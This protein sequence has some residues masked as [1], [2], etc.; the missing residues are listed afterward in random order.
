MWAVTSRNT[1][2]GL[3]V[4]SMDLP[5][6]FPSP[7]VKPYGPDCWPAFEV[8]SRAM[9]H[10]EMIKRELYDRAF[11]E[12]IKVLARRHGELGPD[13]TRQIM[14]YVYDHCQF[15]NLPRFEWYAKYDRASER[16]G[17]RPLGEYEWRTSVK[18]PKHMSESCA[19]KECSKYNQGA[20]Q[21]PS[22]V[23]TDYVNIAMNA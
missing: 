1:H 22:R 6:T 7:Y 15:N 8:I 12:T 21:L 3:N 5:Y 23:L 19:F 17:T 9:L 18:F 16:C 10:K 13:V 14:S 20:F 11:K 2:P 4:V